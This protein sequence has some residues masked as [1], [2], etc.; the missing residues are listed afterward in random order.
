MNVTSLYL[1][2]SGKVQDIWAKQGDMVLNH[3]LMIY[4]AISLEVECLLEP[5]W[6]W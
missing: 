5:S 1:V 6:Y 2:Y 3:Q 4:M